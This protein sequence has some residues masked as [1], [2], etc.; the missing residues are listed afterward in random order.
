MS[1]GPT[2]LN[3][4]YGNSCFLRSMF[5]LWNFQIFLRNRLK[6]HTIKNSIISPRIVTQVICEIFFPTVLV[7]FPFQLNLNLNLKCSERTKF[8]DISL[9]KNKI[10]V[11]RLSVSLLIDT[12]HFTNIS[13]SIQ[14]KFYLSE[15]RH[16]GFKNEM[17]YTKY[18]IQIDQGSILFIY[19]LIIIFQL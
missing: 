2:L 12:N 15:N 14:Y 3:A 19:L 11:F 4:K 5:L 1:A 10:S 9:L 18:Y 17:P 7:V 8:M 16:E 6:F 13:K